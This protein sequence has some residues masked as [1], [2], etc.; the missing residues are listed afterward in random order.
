MEKVN[1]KNIWPSIPCPNQKQLELIVWLVI[2]LI[3]L[4]FGSDCFDCCDSIRFDSTRLDS[5]RFDS[6]VVVVVVVVEVVGIMLHH[7]ECL[8]ICLVIV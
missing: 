6:V 2:R 7:N 1:T 3:L 5:I 4:P 8:M